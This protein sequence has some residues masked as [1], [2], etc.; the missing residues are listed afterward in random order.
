MVGGQCSISLDIT[1][2]NSV[3]S[4]LQAAVE[5]FGRVDYACNVAGILLPGYT[6]EYA[7]DTFDKQYAVNQRGTWLC[8]KAELQQ[9]LKQDPLSI[10]NASNKFASSARGAIA[11]VASMAGLRPYDNL[12]AYCATKAAVLAFTKADGLRHASDGIRVNAICPG[13]IKTAM[14]GEVPNDHDTNVSEMTKE[15]AM[16]RQGL[17][18]EVAEALVWIVSSKASFVTATDLPVNGGRLIRSIFLIDLYCI[19]QL[20]LLTEPVCRYASS[21]SVFRRADAMT[22]IWTSKEKL[23]KTGASL[24]NR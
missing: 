13:V 12:P 20:Y 15:M 17:P 4:L 6:T 16:K 18:E 24:S 1:S 9:M 7:V 14:L 22:L 5:R 3:S 2:E 8:Q 19:L 23:D 21:M 11:N 10:P